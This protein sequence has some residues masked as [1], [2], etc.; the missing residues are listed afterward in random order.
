MS[1]AQIKKI[2]SPNKVN[3]YLAGTNPD[4]ANSFFL[5]DEADEKIIV[6]TVGQAEELHQRLSLNPEDGTPL[7]RW[8]Y[9]KIDWLLKKMHGVE[10]ELFDDP[11]ILSKKGN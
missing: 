2:F 7:D 5:A 4:I 9:P 6:I 10:D 3:E 11:T 8:L 1:Y